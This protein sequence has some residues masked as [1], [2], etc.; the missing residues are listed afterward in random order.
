[1]NKAVFLDRDGVLNELIF[2]PATKEFESPHAPEDLH[3]IDGILP[4]LRRLAEAGF[5]LFLVSNQPSYAKGKTTLENIREIHRRLDAFLKVNGVV[6]C[7]YYYCYHHPKGVTPGYS[8]PCPCRKPAPFFL[9]QAQREH[10]LD[11]SRSWMVGDQ[12]SD[13]LC[14]RNAGCRTVVIVNERSA[15]KRGKVPPEFTVGSLADA[16]DKIIEIKKGNTP[17]D[18]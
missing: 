14:G 3:I 8:G 15:A 4:P 7:E 16:V 9:L 5:G 2:N 13:V 18:G 12:D 10:G 1:M 11:L 6:F 17:H